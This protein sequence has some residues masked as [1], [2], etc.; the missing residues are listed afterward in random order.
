MNK[1]HSALHAIARRD[2]PETTDLWPLIAARIERKDTLS[3]NPKLTLA[4]TF[5]LVLL[6]LILATTAAYA[7]Y[8]FIFNDP[9]LQAVGDAGLVTGVNATAQPTL[10]P[11]PLSFTQGQRAALATQIDGGLTATLVS[12][13]A[14]AHRLSFVVHF[15]GWKPDYA[16]GIPF[17]YDA[18]GVDYNAGR[19]NAAASDSD[20]NTWTINILP[21][22]ELQM[23]RFTGKLHVY[24]ENA[25]NPRFAEF[26]FAVDVPVGKTITFQPMQ[27]GTA[28]G[29][30]IRLEK[31]EMSPS[32]TR[33]YTCVVQTPTLSGKW[34]PFW[35][36]ALP[37]GSGVSP[38][39]EAE[40]KDL[41]A[42]PSS[43][44]ANCATTGF[45]IGY[46]SHIKTLRLTADHLR[47]L[48]DKAI[49]ELPPAD[50][51]AAQ[52]KLA[53]QGIQA[54]YVEPADPSGDSGLRVTKKPAGMDDEAVQWLFMEALG[55]EYP[56]P[57]SF[58]VDLPQ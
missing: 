3:M 28:D 41:A 36:I 7:L 52:Q 46:E 6:G 48:F 39:E 1:L 17:L 34:I 21:F 16:I 10:L 30:E 24:V 4:W 51:Q 15:D 55:I 5:V 23:E 38:D 13:Y 22:S 32:H 44:T 53:A 31:V 45:P 42:G 56:G 14:D 40:Y 35:N 58:T 18:N 47:F 11:D 54:S 8:R 9:G 26:D 57:W 33:I 50:L 27:S 29:I 43:G 37:D 25:D 49:W 19:T 20:P 2:I 12:A